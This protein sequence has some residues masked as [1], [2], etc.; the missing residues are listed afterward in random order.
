M[1]EWTHLAMGCHSLS[2]VPGRLRMV[3]QASNRRWSVCSFSTAGEY[4]RFFSVTTN[5]SLKDWVEH[6]VGM[7]PENHLRT[8]IDM[9]SFHCFGVGNSHLKFFQVF[10]IHP[11]RTQITGSEASVARNL[12][13]FRAFS[14]T[15]RFIILF[16]QQCPRSCLVFHNI[17][18]FW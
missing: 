4:T 8:Y 10:L 9:N 16:K 18:T 6:V 2:K 13:K 1:Q 5:R 12:K 3:W 7:Y 17:L 14:G 15:R 11:L